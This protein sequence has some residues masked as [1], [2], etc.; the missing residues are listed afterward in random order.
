MEKSL[1][2]PVAQLS[3]VTKSRGATLVLSDLTLEVAPGE[4]LA[5]LGPNGAGKS[6]TVG[7][8]TGRLQPDRGNATLF[9]QDPR[10]AS[11]RERLGVMPQQAGLPRLLTVAEQIALF[12]GYYPKPRSLSEILALSGL[13]GLSSRRCTALSGGQQR[14]LHFA[15]AISGKPEFLIL[16]EPTTGLDVDARRSLWDAIRTE[17]KRGAAVLLT[18]HYLEEAESL[19][20]RVVVL[21]RGQVIADGTPESMKANAASAVIRCRTRLSASEVIN[22]PS[23]TSATGE[24]ARI[25]ILTKSAPQTMRALLDADETLSDLSVSGASLE[26]AFLRLTSR[27]TNTEL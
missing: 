18:T 21:D 26:D 3:G 2:S 16:D 17:A 10:L 11:A 9:D 25:S 14:S 20:D 22:M 4:V 23:V 12:R 8:L 5:L 24:G 13:A 6:T 19:A 1:T 15:L 7:L 27:P